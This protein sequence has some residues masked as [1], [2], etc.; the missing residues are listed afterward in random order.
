MVVWSNNK[1]SKRLDALRE[2]PKDEKTAIASV[3]AIGVVAVLLIGWAIWFLHKIT[4]EK[5]TADQGSD[6]NYLRNQNGA[7]GYS[8]NDNAG[9]DIFLNTTGNPPTDQS[10]TN[11]NSDVGY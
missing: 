7:S 4:T 6:F 1:N 9:R 5:S 10:S 11:S 2:K 3:V 8:S